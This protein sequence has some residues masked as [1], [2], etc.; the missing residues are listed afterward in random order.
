LDL[1]INFIVE[2]KTRETNITMTGCGKN[3]KII[4]TNKNNK[5]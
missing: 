5:E 4:A 2:I 3:K 1:G